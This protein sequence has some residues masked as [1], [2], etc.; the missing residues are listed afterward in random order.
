MQVIGKVWGLKAATHASKGARCAFSH[1]PRDN[2]I[3][4]SFTIYFVDT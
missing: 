1:G 4:P 3:S 2:N